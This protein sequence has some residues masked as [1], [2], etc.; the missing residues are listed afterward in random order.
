[1]D[2]LR[3]AHQCVDEVQAGLLTGKRQRSPA[4]DPPIADRWRRYEMKM[5][6]VQQPFVLEGC[7]AGCSFLDYGGQAP[8][9]FLPYNTCQ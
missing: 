8:C 5:L 4:R 1:M 6:A 3:E 2:G 7:T 9:G